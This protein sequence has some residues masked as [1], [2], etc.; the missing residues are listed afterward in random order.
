[1]GVYRLRSVFGEAFEGIG[2]EYAT[3]N[4]FGSVFGNGTEQNAS[5]PHNNWSVVPI[6]VYLWTLE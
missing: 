4:R 3:E 1:M 2:R 6:R 5:K